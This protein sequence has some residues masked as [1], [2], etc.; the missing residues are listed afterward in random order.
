MDTLVQTVEAACTQ[1]LNDV[2]D[3]SLYVRHKTESSKLQDLTASRDALRTHMPDLDLGFLAD[4]IRTQRAALAATMDEMDRCKRGFEHNKKTLRQAIQRLEDT[5]AEVKKREWESQLHLLIASDAPEPS[6]PVTAPE[7]TQVITE[8]KDAY[9]LCKS[10]S[11]A[12]SWM[13]GNPVKTQKSPPGTT[14]APEPAAA[15]VIAYEGHVL[16][17]WAPGLGPAL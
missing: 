10:T 12:D 11:Q 2:V 6:G 4:A 15:N 5:Y 16:C 1:M 13:P 3:T 17:G 14:E 9:V 7:V 8:D